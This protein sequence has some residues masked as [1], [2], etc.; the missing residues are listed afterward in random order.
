MTLKQALNDFP[1]KGFYQSSQ[2]LLMEQTLRSLKHVSHN[3]TLISRF[4]LK[5][6]K[7]FLI[8][9]VQ[10]RVPPPPVQI[11]RLLIMQRYAMSDPKFVQK[12]STL[13]LIQYWNIF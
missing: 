9:C 11:A 12:A 2:K 10:V 7:P 13:L 5:I 8:T 3:W 6:V 4:P 1:R